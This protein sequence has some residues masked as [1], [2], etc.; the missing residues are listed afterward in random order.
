MVRH[1]YQTKTTLIIGETLLPSIGMV[2]GLD[3]LVSRGIRQYFYLP[4]Q[5]QFP[6]TTFIAFG[7]SVGG[8]YLIL[9]AIQSST[10]KKHYEINQR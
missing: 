1:W 8:F 10:L 4:Y 7:L 6:L 2:L 9:L 5:Y 3:A